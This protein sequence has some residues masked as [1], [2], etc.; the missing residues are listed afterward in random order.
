[1]S[2]TAE[3]AKVEFTSYIDHALHTKDTEAAVTIRDEFARMGDDEQ[4]KY[5]HRLVHL[6]NDEEWA[7]DR[8]KDNNNV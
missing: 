2:Y 5:W 4:A 7:Y 3:D 8:D 1:M 6:W